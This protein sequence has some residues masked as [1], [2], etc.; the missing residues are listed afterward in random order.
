[1]KPGKAV[2]SVMYALAKHIASA[3]GFIWAFLRYALE[4]LLCYSYV[5]LGKLLSSFGSISS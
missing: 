4:P 2:C 1:M 5:F 3:A